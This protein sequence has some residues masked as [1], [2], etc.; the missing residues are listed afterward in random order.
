MLTFSPS[1]CCNIQTP[2]PVVMGCVC[3]CL[4][5]SVCVCD[6]H[7]CHDSKQTLH[8]SPCPT[9]THSGWTMLQVCKLT[10]THVEIFFVVIYHMTSA[11][12]VLTFKATLRLQYSF[13]FPSSFVIRVLHT[14]QIY[15][16]SLCCLSACTPA[17]ITT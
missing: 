16:S 13:I 11:C 14:A 15:H 3:V 17:L 1:L 5:I 9:H 7:W 2:H 8:S 6:R 10:Q 4:S 12:L